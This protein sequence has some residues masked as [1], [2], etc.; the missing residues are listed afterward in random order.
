MDHRRIQYIDDYFDSPMLTLQILRSTVS[1]GC[2]SRISYP[3]P[4]GGIT[5]LGAQDIP[6]QN[7]VELA[8]SSMPLLAEKEIRYPGQPVLIIAGEDPGVLKAFIQAVE[9]SYYNTSEPPGFNEY[10]PGQIIMQT[11]L[12]EGNVDKAGEAAAT[13]QEGRYVIEETLPWTIDTQGA[14]ARF[15]DGRL[16]VYSSTQWMH[17]VR[18]TVASALGMR[19]RD[20]TVRRSAYSA[21]FEEKLWYPSILAVYAAL[22]TLKTGI[23]CKMVL[24]PRERLFHGPRGTPLHIHHRSAA[25]KEGRLKAVKVEIDLESGAFPVYSEEVLKRAAMAAA[26][27]Y[28]CKNISVT[29]RLIETA[30]RPLDFSP[31][32]GI[33]GCFFAS[34]VHAGQIAEESGID[35]LSWRLGNLDESA[36]PLAALMEKVAEESDF[37]RK[38]AAYELV[39]KRRNTPGCGPQPLRGIGIAAVYQ[40]NGFFGRGEEAGRFKVTARLESEGDLYIYTSGLSG[41]HRTSSLARRRAAE[42]LGIPRGGVHLIND[43]TDQVPESGPSGLSRNITIVYRLVER[44]CEGI[45]KKRFRTPLPI[46]ATRSFRLSAKNRWDEKSLK[47]NPY[48]AKSWAACVVE[49][50]LAP[51]LLEPTVKGIWSALDCGEI[52]HR[53]RAESALET[54]ILHALEGCEFDIQEKVARGNPFFLPEF[55]QIPPIHLSFNRISQQ[56]YPSGIGDLPHIMVPP[57][58]AAALNQAAGVHFAH[59]PLS[60]RKIHQYMEDR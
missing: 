9:I 55:R 11:T 57:A 2:I 45:K 17:H 38:Y 48:A 40:G 43:D 12:K 49:L 29:A 3:R 24:R 4:P 46:E 47:G 44:C 41:L 34:E 56:K 52:I 59:F 16:T 31:G 18:K 35:P 1:R 21:Q 20:L 8:D 53:H 58:Y 32:A 37:R 30:R 36:A 23:S 10:E 27:T 33:A 50:E 13:V 15:E 5:V 6:G 14:F 60:P 26:G 39:K 7:L 42:I 28:R 54:G 22:A 25:D 19:P 51:V